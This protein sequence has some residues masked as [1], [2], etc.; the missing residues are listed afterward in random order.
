MIDKTADFLRRLR[1]K[2]FFV[3]NSNNEPQKKTYGFNSLRSPPFQPELKNFEDDVYKL[4]KDIRFR[5][6]NDEFQKKLSNDVKVI[7]KSTEIIV[8]ADKSSNKYKMDIDQ[9]K[10][11]LHNCVTTE[12]KKT[13]PE[14]IQETNVE[15]ANLA[16]EMEL[17]DRID[18]FIEAEAFITVKDH[19][20]NFPDR[21]QCRLLNP[22]KSNLGKISKTI[23][24]EAVKEIKSKTL[25]QQWQNTQDVIS[26]FSSLE[27]KKDLSFFKFDVVSFYPSISE[28]LF[29]DTVKWAN[30]LIP[31]EN[32]SLELLYHSRKSFLFTDNATWIKKS[33][34][35]NFDVTMGAY[36][37]AEVCELV[38]LYLL[39]KLQ[40]YFPKEDIGLYRDDGLAVVKLSGPQMASLR[41]KIIKIFKDSGLKV[42]IE[43]NLKQTNFLDVHLDL[44][45]NK[46]KPYKKNNHETTY[47]HMKSN[48]P[49]SI[50]KQ[51]PNMIGHRLSLLSNSEET[52][53]SVIGPYEDSLQKA[54]YTEKL[55][56]ESQDLNEKK[57]RKR[58][59]RKNIIWFNPPFSKA[60]STNLGARFLKLIDKH[61]PRGSE[62]GRI[63]NRNTVK[64]SYSCLPNMENIISSH[65]KKL[66]RDSINTAQQDKNSTC[67]CRNKLKPCPLEKQCLKK[68]IIYKAEVT[69]NTV[70]HFP[71]SSNSTTAEYIGLASNS[72]KERYNNHQLSFRHE[73]YQ[74][75]T[76]LSKYIWDLRKSSIPFNIDWSV[77]CS[78]S[79]YHP[80]IKKCP[81]CIM[82]KTQILM[83]DH[84]F[85]LNKK[86]EL[87]SKCRHREKFL[88]SNW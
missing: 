28:S 53:K 18:Q 35:N 31:F 54:G 25:Y 47:I 75:N 67:N 72:F 88:L 39:S 79:T 45:K 51:L 87:L 20:K 55:K 1:W 13:N 41:K 85:P 30:N 48:H 76:S 57:K 5:P 40:K 16:K 62:L 66:L 14:D 65:N 6:V 23:L 71:M 8:S 70:Q 63:F 2:L 69:S 50:L 81:L 21:I 17:D 12:Y 10:D 80:S 82:E 52:F 36:D 26:W 27:N 42:T 32:K 64:I 24:E 22:A 15:A 59:R 33:G 68:S 19:K 84:K 38:G 73:K 58:T 46:Y 83:S 9:Y 49:R 78:A 4:I 34:N 74:S 56:Y 29:S 37:G 60:V 7:L 43:V 11:L 61:F 3:Q 44:E 77:V 86:S